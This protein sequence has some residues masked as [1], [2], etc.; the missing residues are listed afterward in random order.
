SSRGALTLWL[1]ARPQRDA[2]AM[3]TCPHNQSRAQNRAEACMRVWTS[4]G[5]A[6]VGIGLGLGLASIA[7]AAEDDALLKD[8]RSIFAPLPNSMAAAGRPMT[9]ALVELGRALYFDPRMSVVGTTSCAR[10]HQPAFYGADALAKSHGNHDRLNARNAP[11]VLN[12]ALQ[13]KQH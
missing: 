7:Q 5:T 11:T 13:V 1:G 6:A 4:F 8:A 10:C 3:A 9:T 2:V 12:T